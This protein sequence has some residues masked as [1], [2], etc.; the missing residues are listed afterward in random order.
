MEGLTATTVV[1]GDK[2]KRVQLRILKRG[3]MPVIVALGSLGYILKCCSFVTYICSVP[4]R[5]GLL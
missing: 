1:A 5:S 2:K 4:N 3:T